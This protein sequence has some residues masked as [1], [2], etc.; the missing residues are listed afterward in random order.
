MSRACNSLHAEPP[1][2]VPWLAVQSP[3]SPVFRYSG[4]PA[5]HPLRELDVVH[6]RLVEG[7]VEELGLLVGEVALGLFF[8]DGQRVDVVLGH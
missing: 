7:L 6:P 1:G 2:A 3:G 5:S 8:Q 4:I